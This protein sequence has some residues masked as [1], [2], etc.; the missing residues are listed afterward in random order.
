MKQVILPLR[1]SQHDVRSP[2]LL[3]MVVLLHNP[4]QPALV[5]DPQYLRL[6]RC[7]GSGR[8]LTRRPPNYILGIFPW[9]Y[10]VN[11]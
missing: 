5:L 6:K 11:L 1:H 3:E 2:R 8:Q 7:E 4:F 9:Q 10:L